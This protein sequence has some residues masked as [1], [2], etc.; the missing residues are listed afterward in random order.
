MMGRFKLPIWIVPLAIAGMVAMVGW[1]GDTRLKQ[2]IEGQVAAG[3]TS[4]LDANVTSLGIWTTNQ[5]KLADSLAEEP[6][7]R[8]EYRLMP[9]R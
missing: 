9:D 2:V 4:T 3:L 1:W 7:V 8:P 5:M 6:A